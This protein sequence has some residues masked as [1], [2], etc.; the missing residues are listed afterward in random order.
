MSARRWQNLAKY[1]YD[2]SKLIVAS[3]VVTHL[4]EHPVFNLKLVVFGLLAGIGFLLIGLQLD[5][6]GEDNER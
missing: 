3:A 4:V 5:R 1:F 2:I 6:K